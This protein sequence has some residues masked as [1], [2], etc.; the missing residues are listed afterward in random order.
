MPCIKIIRWLQTIEQTGVCT[1]CGRVSGRW[2]LYTN[3]IVKCI[4]T[5]HFKL[6]VETITIT[7]TIT[8]TVTITNVQT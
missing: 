8:V 5:A 1:W 2:C 6:A 3:S 7:V 4:P